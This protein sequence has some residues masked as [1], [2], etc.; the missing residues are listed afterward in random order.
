MQNHDDRYAPTHS[1]M[2]SR[3]RLACFIALVSLGASGLGSGCSSSTDSAEPF[4][5]Y[6]G[7]WRLTADT[8]LSN[9]F[10]L[11]C[12]N[13]MAALA[14]DVPDFQLFTDVV[15]EPGKLADLYESAG[16]GDCQFSYNVVPKM[17]TSSVV[18]PDPFT[19]MATT[20][21]VSVNS[22]VDPATQ[23]TIRTLLVITPTSWVFNLKAPVKGKAP[24]AQ[25]IAN[26]KVALDDVDVSTNPPSLLDT[27]DCTYDILENLDKVSQL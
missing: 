6:T 1:D 13:P 4:E 21:A 10:H 26:A 18:N 27:T 23:D 16:P 2:G 12:P 9:T 15:M 17:G 19:G 7:R 8:T 5:E 25:L 3:P 22:S 14:I 24:G 11:S 20:C